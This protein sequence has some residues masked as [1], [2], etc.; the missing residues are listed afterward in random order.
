MQPPMWQG[1]PPAV[2]DQQRKSSPVG[3]Q[4]ESYTVYDY[5]QWLGKRYKEHALLFDEAAD[6]LA[7]EG[8]VLTTIALKSEADIKDVV[9]KSG[10]ASLLKSRIKRFIN[11]IESRSSGSDTTETGR[12][13]R[14]R[15]ECESARNITS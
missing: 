14:V 13:E 3:S 11:E 5:C 7:D 15:I 2:L 4:A 6:A 1:G 8:W 9:R 10:V 12:A